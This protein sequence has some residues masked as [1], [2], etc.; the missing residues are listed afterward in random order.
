MSR[1]SL[2]G[3]CYDLPR[4]L[5]GS[6]DPTLVPASSGSAAHTRSKSPSSRRGPVAS[7][8]MLEANGRRRRH[9]AQFVCPDCKQTFTALFSL[10]RETH[11]LCYA[12]LSSNTTSRS[13][14]E[15]HWRAP[16]CMQRPRLHTTILQ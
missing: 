6:F 11:I 1:R 13:Y 7:K 16:L 9:P 5:T 10:K 2:E 8:A 4:S 12:R 14:A 3:L 15:P